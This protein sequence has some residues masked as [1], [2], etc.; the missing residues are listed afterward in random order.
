MKDVM[1]PLRLY[2]TR[3]AQ[4]YAKA[5]TNYMTVLTINFGSSIANLIT[6]DTRLTS[7]DKLG[8][9]GGEFG[10]FVGLSFVGIFDFITIVVRYTASRFSNSKVVDQGTK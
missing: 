2:K 9:I 10:L 6:K 1:V 5:R 8:V 3:N 7:S 4:E